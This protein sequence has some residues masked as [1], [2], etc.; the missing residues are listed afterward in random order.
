METSP[1][2]ELDSRIEKVKIQL[3]S[4]ELLPPHERVNKRHYANVELKRLEYLRGQIM[5][6]SH[7]KFLLRDQTVPDHLLPDHLKPLTIKKPKRGNYNE[8]LEYLR[9]HKDP[10]MTAPDPVLAY[11]GETP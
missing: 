9:T 7:G 6:R 11:L 3:A 10:C 1:C 8:V 5:A 2:P 4:I